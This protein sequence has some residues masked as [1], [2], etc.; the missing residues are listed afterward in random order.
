MPIINYD[1]Y[2][3]PFAG[4]SQAQHR[5][6]WIRRNWPTIMQ[7]L[8]YTFLMSATVGRSII[9]RTVPKDAEIGPDDWAMLMQAAQ[10]INPTISQSEAATKLCQLFGSRAPMCR[11]LLPGQQPVI[12]PIS[13]GVTGEAPGT[14]MGIPAWALLGGLGLVAVMLFK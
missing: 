6:S 11:D 3:L 2:D 8:G 7:V 14:I 1:N 4:F 9:D 5:P 13:K 10:K 12:M